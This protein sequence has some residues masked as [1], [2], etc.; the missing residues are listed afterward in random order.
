ML[1]RAISFILSLFNFYSEKLLSIR[2]K[3]FDCSFST[4]P[5]GLSAY[6]AN[7]ETELEKGV[8]RS[9]P[10]LIG[11]FGGLNAQQLLAKPFI[12]IASNKRARAAQRA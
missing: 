1:A 6:T 7:R 2:F 12:I 9:A 10:A 3:V 5:V 11:A 4:T 8:V